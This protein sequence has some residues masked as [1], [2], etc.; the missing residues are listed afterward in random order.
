MRLKIA[1]CSGSVSWTVD[2]RMA[3]RS[4]VHATPPSRSASARAPG[5][6][7]RRSRATVPSRD[8]LGARRPRPPRSPARSRPEVARSMRRA[9]R[10]VRRSRG[11]STAAGDRRSAAPRASRSR[12][13]TPRDADRRRSASAR[14]ATSSPTRP[15]TGFRRHSLHADPVEQRVACAR[16]LRRV[17]RAVPST[18]RPPAA[19][20]TRA[21]GFAASAFTAACT[22]VRPASP[23]ASSRAG[24]ASRLRRQ[25]A[26]RSS[27]G[28]ALSALTGR[29]L[30][31]P[32]DSVLVDDALAEAV[33]RVDGHLVDAGQ[34][35]VAPSARS[36]A[37]SSRPAAKA[38][39]K[40]VDRRGTRPI[41][42]SSRRP[43]CAMRCRMAPSS[44]VAALVKV[45]T[46]N[47]SMPS[48]RSISARTTSPAM[49]RSFPCWRR[50]Q[51]VQPLEDA[52]VEDRC[53]DRLAFT[54]VPRA[55]LDDRVVEHGR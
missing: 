13:A 33:D 21:S 36:A 39:Q 49:S 43:S 9:S 15:G 22:G 30:G 27:S 45:T 23:N 46:S 51:Q 5:E 55:G 31:T 8:R 17:R 14:R 19:G 7:G 32:I 2:Q 54:R 52:G 53:A 38:T 11:S 16:A 44:A 25:S 6:A 47:R 28:A 40:A 41:R 1:H 29:P 18:A 4:G 34:R 3:L 48:S 12:R 26:S 24:E 50:P 42:S 10:A 20:S 37:V 35:N